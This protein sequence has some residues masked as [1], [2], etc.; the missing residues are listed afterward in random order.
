MAVAAMQ[1]SP[2]QQE[3]QLRPDPVTLSPVLK[4]QAAIATSPDTILVNVAGTKYN[5]GRSDG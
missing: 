2:P 3:Q 5:V 1:P 4:P